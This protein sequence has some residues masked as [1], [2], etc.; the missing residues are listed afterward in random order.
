[1]NCDFVKEKI[2][3]GVY[4]NI[5]QLDDELIRHIDDCDACN[6]YYGDCLSA[7]KIT[8]LLNQREPK[9]NDPQKLTNDIL[10]SINDLETEKKSES[11]TIFIIA[12]RFLAAASVCL[13]I[14]FGYEQY[15]VMEKMI[16]LEDQ[17]SV[18][19]N[20]P[21]NSSYY[22]E[23]LRNF[24][25]KG[26]ELIKSQLAAM[27]MESRDEELK[28]LFMK[29]DF[30]VLSHDAISKRLKSQLSHLK[31]SDEDIKLINT[32]IEQ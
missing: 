9:L 31:I 28:S 8:S 11:S 14:V 2:Y 3:E 23:M 18:V 30:G 27:G 12:K 15:V 20:P 24:P 7:K 26:V 5:K 4:S 13:M 6:S 1:M 25:D 22:L 17:M 19:T 21:I 16:K 10:D 29:A 32:I